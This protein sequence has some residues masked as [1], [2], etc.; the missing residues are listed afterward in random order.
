MACWICIGIAGDAA[1]PVARFVF[2]VVTERQTMDVREHLL[3]QGAQYLLAM[4]VM[5]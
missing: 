1:H 4:N 3:A 5:R 2:A